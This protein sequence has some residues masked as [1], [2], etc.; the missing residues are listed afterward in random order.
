[1]FYF[2]TL[3]QSKP[4][5]TPPTTSQQVCHQS[6]CVAQVHDLHRTHYPRPDVMQKWASYPE[7]RERVW[8]LPVNLLLIICVKD[9]AKQG[10]AMQHIFFAEGLR[11]SGCP[12]SKNDSLCLR[13]N[14]SEHTRTGNAPQTLLAAVLH[15]RIS[16]FLFGVLR[17]DPP[18]EGF[19]GPPGR[20]TTRSVLVPSRD[21]SSETDDMYRGRPCCYR[22][23]GRVSSSMG[24]DTDSVCCSP[25][26]YRDANKQQCGT[27]CASSVRTL[28][29]KAP[30]RRS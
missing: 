25:Q 19:R 9:Q 23:G 14:P 1:M 30:R 3:H 6:T 11:K 7:R 29:A 21:H 16:F 17:R 2:T 8:R 5:S 27:P 24:F 12:Q 26:A 20:C 22:C 28:P 10:W 15:R 4:T 13:P 18:Y